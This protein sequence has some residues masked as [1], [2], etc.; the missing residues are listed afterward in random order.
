MAFYEDPEVNKSYLVLDF[1]GYQSLTQFMSEKN[2]EMQRKVHLIEENAAAAT[3]LQP[4]QQQLLS[5][6]LVR[7]I[8]V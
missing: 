1:S 7:E 5:E 4:Q 8:M 6:E 3:S 2:K